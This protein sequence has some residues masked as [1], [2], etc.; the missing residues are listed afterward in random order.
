MYNNIADP[1]SGKIVAMDSK[2]G[3]ELLVKYLQGGGSDAGYKYSVKSTELSN[4]DKFNKLLNSMIQKEL[5]NKIETR[6]EATESNSIYKQNLDKNINMLLQ[7][8][9]DQF[10]QKV[11]KDSKVH[12]DKFSPRSFKSDIKNILS[13]CK[14]H[15]VSLITIQDMLK[16]KQTNKDRYL[17]MP[18]SIGK[19]FIKKWKSDSKMKRRRS[20]KRFLN[21]RQ[22]REVKIERYAKHA[23]KSIKGLSSELSNFKMDPISKKESFKL[24]SEMYK[25]SSEYDKNATSKYSKLFSNKTK[26]GDWAHSVDKQG[27]YKLL[28]TVGTTKKINIK[29]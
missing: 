13:F 1:V 16:T 3:K 25:L 19:N 5:L 8:Y 29:Q 26:M 20:D 21:L 23:S 15:I 27:N 9:F 22:T 12:F 18:K 28:E 10:T 14:D 11:L 17:N 4:M 24:A 6:Q 7:R 2:L